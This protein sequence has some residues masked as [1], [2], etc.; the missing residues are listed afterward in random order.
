MVEWE[1]RHR[2]QSGPGPV[3][4]KVVMRSLKKKTALHV[5][6][7]GGLAVIVGPTCGRRSRF[8]NGSLCDSLS[9][10]NHSYSRAFFMSPPVLIGK[11]QVQ[12]TRGRPG[13]VSIQQFPAPRMPSTAFGTGGNPAAVPKYCHAA[14]AIASGM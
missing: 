8:P 7:Q 1:R 2:F 11:H 5:E 3:K 12:W 6:M 13:V 14:S 4:K 9:T 10:G